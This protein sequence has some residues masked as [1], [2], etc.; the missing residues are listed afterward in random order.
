VPP[1]RA[2]GRRRYRLAGASGQTGGAGA[3]QVSVGA[4][5]RLPASTTALSRLT[6]CLR[7]LALPCAP[8][9]PALTRCALR[10]ASCRICRVRGC[11][12]SGDRD[13]RWVCGAETAAGYGRGS[14]AGRRPCPF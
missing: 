7:S 10:R 13:E 6:A 3:A 1:V 9:R 14:C 8:D 2:A 12:S 5:L 11:A 4:H